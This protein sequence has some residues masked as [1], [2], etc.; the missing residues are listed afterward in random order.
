M[1]R[2]AAHVLQAVRPGDL[3]MADRLIEKKERSTRHVCSGHAP[4]VLALQ[5]SLRSANE[6]Y[7]MLFFDLGRTGVDMGAEILGGKHPS[8]FGI[9]C[10]FDGAFDAPGASAHLSSPV[11]RDK[12]RLSEQDRG[13]KRYVLLF[14]GFVSGKRTLFMVYC[15][16]FRR[17]RTGT[18]GWGEAYKSVVARIPL[19]RH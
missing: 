11:A 3:A 1:P 15:N 8:W 13:H 14:Q 12:L 18:A 4:V 6:R 5:D 17:S 19:S 2:L 16:H 9:K 7:A 10:R